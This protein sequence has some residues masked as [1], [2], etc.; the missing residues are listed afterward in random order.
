MSIGLRSSAPGLKPRGGGIAPSRASRSYRVFAPSG[1]LGS[2]ATTIT[3][4]PLE[5]TIGPAL[6]AVSAPAL[7]STAP[8]ASFEVAPERDGWTQ[9]AEGRPDEAL[10]IFSDEVYLS[11][12]RAVARV[13]KALALAHEGHLGEGVSIMRSAVRID[14]AALEQAPV[15]DRIRLALVDLLIAYAA[16]R[17]EHG[18]G[19]ADAAFMRSSL[20]VLRRDLLSARDA[21]SLGLLEDDVSVSAGNLASWLEAERG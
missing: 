2:R 15:D 9:L 14:P 13:G 16:D 1:T 18:I 5:A 6:E 3:L 8:P 20:H 7:V 10:R 19:V 4:G 11:P 21:L 12:D 17:P